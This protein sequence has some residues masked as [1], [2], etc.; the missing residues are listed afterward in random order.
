MSSVNESAIWLPRDDVGK[1]MNEVRE[2]GI[3]ISGVL[4]FSV[5]YIYLVRALS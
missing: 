2:V 4:Y 3:E 1:V 5:T